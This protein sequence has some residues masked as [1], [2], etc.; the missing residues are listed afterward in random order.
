MPVNIIVGL[1]ALLVALVT[2]SIGT[3][4]AFRAKAVSAK[5]L[6]MLWIGVAFDVLATVMMGLQ[7]GGLDLSPKGLWHTV[8]ALAAFFGMLAVAAVGTW[9]QRA[10]RDDILARLSRWVLAPWALWVIVF[11]WGMATRGAARMGG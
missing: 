10:G 11:L 9:A 2:Y 7:S 4:G 6:L 5:H 3:W 1:V 8:F